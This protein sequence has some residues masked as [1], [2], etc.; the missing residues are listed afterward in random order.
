MYPEYKRS[1]WFAVDFISNIAL[2]IVV[3]VVNFLLLLYTKEVIDLVLNSTAVFFALELDESL[4]DLS[5]SCIRNLHRPF[6]MTDLNKKL[7]KVDQ[8]YW[9]PG[10]DCVWVRWVR[11]RFM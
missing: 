3:C 2:G 7:K 8:R 1:P 4:V 10:K 6:I 5:E 9:N 11:L